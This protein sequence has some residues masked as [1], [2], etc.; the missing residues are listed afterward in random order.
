[1]WPPGSIFRGLTAYTPHK[2]RSEFGSS[3]NIPVLFFVCRTANASI[4]HSFA[5]NV[6]R[7]AIEGDSNVAAIP[8]GYEGSGSECHF[9]SS[10]SQGK[11]ARFSPPQPEIYKR[12]MQ[13][14]PVLVQPGTG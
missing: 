9:L 10:G 2:P 1:M 11:T 14:Q 13:V 3:S 5:S 12:L 7:K 4:V 6:R 8:S